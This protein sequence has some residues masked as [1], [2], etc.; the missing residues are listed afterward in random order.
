[1]YGGLETSPA[2]SALN[3]VLQFNAKVTITQQ[4][5]CDSGLVQLDYQAYSRDIT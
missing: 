2:R 5:V 4:A 1:M 3:P